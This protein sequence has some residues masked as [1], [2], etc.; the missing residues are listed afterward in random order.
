MDYLD[1]QSLYLVFYKVKKFDNF[2]I[3]IVFIFNKEDPIVIRVSL[4]NIDI[5]IVFFLR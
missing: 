3:N 5:P 2:I 4:Q 1:F